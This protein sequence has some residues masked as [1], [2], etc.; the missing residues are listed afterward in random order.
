MIT[1]EKINLNHFYYFFNET[2]NIDPNFLGIN[3]TNL[4]CCLWNQTYH[5]AKY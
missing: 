2:E 5:D 4:C 1:F 3:K